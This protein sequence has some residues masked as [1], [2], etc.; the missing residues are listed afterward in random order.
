[1]RELG[2]Q[3]LITEMDVNDRELAGDDAVRDRAVA[4]VY[5][6]YLDVMLKDANVTAVVT[7]GI[8]DRRTWL[9]EE[10]QRA[11][12]LRERCLPFDESMKPVKAFFAI[13]D[14]IDRQTR[15]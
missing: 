9:N 10:N 5:A 11:D 1:M 14:A 2:L 3:V 6:R 15:A 13:R 7:W 12:G 4:E 8:T